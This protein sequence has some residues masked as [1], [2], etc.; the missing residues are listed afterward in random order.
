MLPPRA[1]GNVYVYGARLTNDEEVMKFTSSGT[2]LW[3]KNFATKSLMSNGELAVG[4]A[5]DVYI[6]GSFRGT[7]D[8][9]PSAKTKLVSSGA[10]HAG[11]VL[12]LDTNGKI[13]WVSSFLGK[14]GLAQNTSYAISIAIDG[15][16]SVIVG[17]DFRGTVDFNPGSGTS[18]LTQPNGGFI[19][20]LNTSG[21][22]VWAKQLQGDSDLFVYG[23]DTDA[24]GNIYASG[25][26]HGTA[27]FN[28]SSAVV[29]RTS[30][31]Q[32]DLFVLRLRATG[33]LA[34]AE[35]FGGTGY[36]VFQGLAVTTAGDILV[37]GHYTDPFDV[38]PDPFATEL[39]P[40]GTANRGLRLRLRQL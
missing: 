9:D 34:W 20:K 30:A 6:A 26:F 2:Q 36:D 13:G 19:A 40:G 37:G 25:T 27:D 11:Y 7:V 10:G 29:S 31:G 39:L 12:N 38:N 14:S 3:S 4:A 16:G 21:G 24:A 1:A 35:T 32:T 18:Y 5:G 17:G 15:S 22:L 28:H 33:N 23:L 8:F